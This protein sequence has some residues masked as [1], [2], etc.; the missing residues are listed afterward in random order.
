M[1]KAS[2]VLERAHNEGKELRRF[3]KEGKIADS[4]YRYD[5]EEGAF[6][7]YCGC[8]LYHLGLPINVNGRNETDIANAYSL[9]IPQVIEIDNRFEG[10]GFRTHTLGECAEWLKGIGK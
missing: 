8:A 7:I 4:S 9:T 10:D 2:E 5:G 6:G 3:L 1:L